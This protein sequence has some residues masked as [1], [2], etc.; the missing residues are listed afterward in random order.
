MGFR[1]FTIPV[2]DVGQASAELNAFLGNHKVL[3]VDR[4]W[5]EQGPS[6]FWCFCIDYLESPN[7]GGGVEIG[8]P[9]VH[10]SK[11]DY[12]EV[13]PPE[14]FTRFV[15]LRDLRKEIAQAEAVPVYTIFTNEQLA[16]MVKMD[17]TTK[18]ALEKVAGIGEARTAKYGDRFL[19]LLVETRKGVHEASG[20]PV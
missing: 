1:F 18:A 16:Q 11:V 7:G 17:V 9:N 10:R 5:V 4:R 13:L 20:K 8:R 2:Q 12:R 19:A 14:Q 6:S 15:K 3:A